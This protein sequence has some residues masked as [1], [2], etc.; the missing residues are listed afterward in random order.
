MPA[1][2]KGTAHLYGIEGTVTNATVL[3]FSDKEECKNTAATQDESGNEIERRYDDVHVDATITIRMRAD[4]TRPTIASTLAYNS[5]T[6]EVVSTAKD[7]SNNGFRE[8]TLTLK[9]SANIS[10]A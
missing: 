5:V 3:K 10:Y 9:K 1:T 4:Y 7:T 8:L 6:Y 2:V